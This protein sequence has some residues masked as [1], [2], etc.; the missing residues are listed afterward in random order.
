MFSMLFAASGSWNLRFAWYLCS[1]SGLQVSI[2]HFAALGSWNRHFAYSIICSISSFK[3]TFWKVFV[4]CQ[5]RMFGFCMIYARFWVS[6]LAFWLVLVTCARWSLVCVFAV[7]VV[8]A[9]GGSCCCCCC[10]GGGGGVLV[11][12]LGC[13]SSCSCSCSGS[14][15]LNVV[16]ILIVSLVL[17]CWFW[18]L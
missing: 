8:A 12:V 14:W 13:C 4:R 11:F 17:G 6:K 5:G 3:F 16:V 10:C 7:V 2:L 15:F 18:C 9:A 1:I